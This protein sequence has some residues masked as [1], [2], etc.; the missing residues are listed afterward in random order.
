VLTSLPVQHLPGN[1]TVFFL[2]VFFKYL[3]NIFYFLNYFLFLNYLKIQ[4]KFKKKF[5][6]MIEPQK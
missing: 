3:N 6:N 4:K 5:K 2:N 1:V